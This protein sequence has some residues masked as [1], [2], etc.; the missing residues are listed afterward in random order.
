MTEATGCSTRSH[1]PLRWVAAVALWGLFCAGGASCPRARDLTNDNAPI[2]LHPDATLE[3]VIRVVNANSAPVRQ[4]QSEGARLQVPGLPSLEATYALERPR[5]FRLRAETR[6]TG[7]ELDLG[8]NDSVYWLWVKRQQNGAVFWGRHDQFQYSAARSLLPVSPD[9]LV[10]AIG[11][12]QLEPTGQ[13]QGPYR[14]RPGQLEIRSQVDSP[15]GPMTRVTVVDD[16]RGWVLAQYLSNPS[17]ETLATANASGFRYYSQFAVS[18]PRH[19]KIGL[20]TIQLQFHLRTERHLINQLPPDPGQLW[21]MPR[22]PSY[23]Y[24]DL[25]NP[26]ASPSSGQPYA[27]ATM[28]QDDPYYQRATVPRSARRQAAIRRLPPFERLR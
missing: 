8:S 3:Q 9:W 14:V 27:Q 23:P 18:L 4:L 13:H 1:A 17:G 19:V 24:V 28:R 16:Q 21:T 7:P 22:M 26:S 2:L 12:V 11:V 20:P 5:R 15:T 6:L 25:S 10:Q